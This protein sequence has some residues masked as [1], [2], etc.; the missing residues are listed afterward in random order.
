MSPA[1]LSESGWDLPGYGDDSEGAGRAGRSRRSAT[2]PSA[3]FGPAVTGAGPEAWR[4]ADGRRLRRWQQVT[5]TTRSTRTGRT[6][7]A[8]GR[9]QATN[10]G[11]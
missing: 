10:E 6:G 3:G 1:P 2:D 8:R 7:D 9:R 4:A 5:T 11:P